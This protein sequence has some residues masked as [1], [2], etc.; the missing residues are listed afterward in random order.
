[1][2]TPPLSPV[3]PRDADPLAAA[4]LRER[5]IRTLAIILRTLLVAFPLVLL[6]MWVTHET[7]SSLASVAL[8]ALCVPV[9]MMMLR[10]GDFET[11]MYG[12]VLML[13]AGGTLVM[14]SAGTIRSFGSLGMVG[15]VTACGLFLDRRRLFTAVAVSAACLGGVAIAE[16]AGWLARP[17]LQTGIQPWIIL[18]IAL[19]AI[20]LNI[21]SA[22]QLL[23][24]VVERLQDELHRR[25]AAE[26]ALG[27]REGLLAAALRISPTPV[28]V[29]TLEDGL[30]RDANEA[31][32]RV[33]GIPLER[34]VGRTVEDAGI[35]AN[36]A[37]RG[38][39]VAR[40]LA[41]G[42]LEN[43]P[44]R[45]HRQQGDFD[46]LA[47]ATI[48][49]VEGVRHVMTSLTEITELIEA[50]DALRRS[51]ERFRKMFELG[52][53][54]MSITRLA[55]GQVLDINE[56]M[57]RLLGHRRA[58]AVGG[59]TLTMAVWESA[60]DRDA[61]VAQ[62]RAG[63]R[64]AGQE[65]RLR[66]REGSTFDVQ[67]WAERM[68]LEGEPCML[69]A[70][71]NV[72]EQKRERALLL[73]I[74]KGV[75]AESG[76]A[77]L[78]S[79]VGHLQRLTGADLALVGEIRGEH[80]QTLAVV[81]DGVPAANFRYDL[82]GSPCQAAANGSP[83]AV[84]F[85]PDRVADLFPDDKALAQA[86]I[87]GY[88]GSCLRDAGGQPIGIVNA[89]RRTPY[90]STE[91]T[92]APFRIFAARARAEL[93]RLRDDREI[94]ALN[95]TLEQRV[96][97]RTQQLNEANEELRAFSYSVSH[98]LRAPLRAING[99]ASIL[100]EDAGHKLSEGERG[101]L[102]RCIAASRRMGELIDDLIGLARVGQ[103][104]LDARPA[105]LTALA[106]EVATSVAALHPE[107]HVEIAVQP[108]LTA[109]CDRDLLRI[110]FDNLLGNAWKFTGRR[111]DARVEVGEEDTPEGPAFFVRD[112]GA[113]FDARY[114]SQLF[115]PFQRLHSENEFPGTGIGLATVARVV[116]RHG[117]RIWAES[118]PGHGA[119]FRFTLG[120]AARPQ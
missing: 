70:L 10:R 84:C 92:E 95:D 82:Q 24:E 15:A 93:Q 45:L 115:R 117:G 16:G 118:Q 44:C 72:T 33:F 120:A 86:G 61:I 66:S 39:Y 105:D 87:R 98:D 62:I 41:D 48:V 114:A 47:S 71:V 9:L 90:E 17:H 43:Y 56:T 26:K 22:R 55:D 11:A 32:T 19:V 57:E 53:I 76:E 18:T 112:N 36:P 104:E 99:F 38:P 7:P 27:E 40:L 30:I 69:A 5:S 28:V 111:S 88:L 65:V 3:P 21:Q 85:F 50:R 80:V 78:R 101:L 106:R 59:S 74:A 2:V 96:Q 119:T 94:R 23:L 75:S 46:A 100:N 20:G 31:Y 68:D 60:A 109:T 12:L 107:R 4:G 13:I 81:R 67:L 58:E 34:L 102:E 91:R 35:W 113:G 37:E 110:V 6:V 49:V 79:L 52:P 97:L 51:E 103:R 25:E 64:V 29:A 54:A 63:G 14:V 73:D 83:E 89:L 42:R 8:M 108:G 77:L 116:A 1:M